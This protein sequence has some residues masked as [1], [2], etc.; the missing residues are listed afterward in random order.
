MFSALGIS[1]D[2]TTSYG[3][4]LGRDPKRQKPG[5]PRT[6]T[7]DSTSDSSLKTGISVV[8][9]EDTPQ[10]LEGVIITHEVEQTWTEQEPKRP[11]DS[12]FLA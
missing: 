3:A 4:Y 7:S 8:A 1:R 11:R 10:A 2:A 9:K 12:V 5:Q 6:R